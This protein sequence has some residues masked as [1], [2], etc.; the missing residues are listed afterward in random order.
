VTEERANPGDGRKHWRRL[1]RQDTGIE[2]FL[3]ARANLG[4]LERAKPILFELS[5]L[6]NP[7]IDGPLIDRASYVRIV[8]CLEA[9]RLEEARR[10]LDECLARYAP[11]EGGGADPERYRQGAGPFHEGM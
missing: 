9:G 5:R 1:K 2:L 3:T 6:Y 4:D 11:G 10:V 7:L 8:E